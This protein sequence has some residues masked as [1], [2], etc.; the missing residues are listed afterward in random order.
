MSTAEPLVVVI[1]GAAGF[2]GSSITA[3]L[4]RKHSVVAVD[5]REPDA[6][7]LR[8]APG[9]Q[10]TKLDIAEAST[11]AA[12][13]QD[14]K[15][16]FGRID[17]VVHLAAFYHFGAD[18][19]P[20]YE[21]TNVRGTAHV[22]RAATDAGA[23]RLIFA[24]SVAAM[25]PARAGESLDETSP[26]SDYL[27]YAASKSTGERMVLEASSGLPAIVLRIG[28]VFS[29]WC[30]LPPLH[31]LIKNWW[32]T[33]P[34]RRVVAGR[35]ESG[36]PYV[37][38]D[39]LVRLVRACLDHEAELATHEVFIA[40][41][42]GT[43]LQRDLFPIVRQACGGAVSPL[44]VSPAIAGLGLRAKRV[45]GTLSG[46][47]PFERPWMLEFLD[48]P[49]VVDTS[50]TRERLQWA[51]TPALGVCERLPTILDHLLR[52]PREW[53]RRNRLRSATRRDYLSR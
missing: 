35:G 34:L 16:S 14:V 19:H 40:S 33:S 5:W 28:G 46:N 6:S 37:H 36:L 24:S 9:V 47:A 20:E 26:T 2:L 42:H 48:R 25:E 7:L 38:R 45:L 53:E 44:F 4:A 22:L 18:A 41:Q 23:A 51:C 11:V 13:F 21:R 52:E 32:G 43:V 39:D 1:T 27:P 12:A 49:W 8:A 30:E 29:D 10:W 15:R 3:D 31:G 50:T 17:V